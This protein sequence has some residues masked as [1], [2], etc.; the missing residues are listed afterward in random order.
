MEASDE[1]WTLQ[2]TFNGPVV[3]SPGKFG[4]CCNLRHRET[5]C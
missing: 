1:H 5:R 3:S 2:R 4:K